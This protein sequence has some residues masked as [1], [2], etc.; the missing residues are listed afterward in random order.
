MFKYFTQT[1]KIVLLF[2]NVVGVYCLLCFGLPTVL[3]KVIPTIANIFISYYEISMND[4][5]T[6]RIVGWGVGML[7]TIMW[8]LRR[9]NIKIKKSVNR[10]LRTLPKINIIISLVLLGI[11][12]RCAT[13]LLS[14]VIT[15]LFSHSAQNFSDAASYYSSSNIFLF[16]LIAI[17]IGPI[18]EEFMFRYIIVNRLKGI[19]S[20]NNKI[21]FVQALLFG[22]FHFNFAQGSVAFFVGIVCMLVVLWTGNILSGI[23]VH[24]ANNALSVVLMYFGDIFVSDRNYYG[25]SVTT[26][27]N[28]GIIL[29]SLFS[30]VLMYIIYKNRKFDA[31][32]RKNP[33]PKM[34][35]V[36]FE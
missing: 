16:S 12:L 36:D 24:A 32:S 30:L 8:N 1:K 14:E 9:A 3:L 27:F 33:Y 35:R 15:T 7:L 13:E 17:I 6:F 5:L 28:Y 11:S 20:S 25:M 10:L 18:T 34:N 21:I 22:V 4:E 26:L 29:I 19:L 2:L 31:L 23:I